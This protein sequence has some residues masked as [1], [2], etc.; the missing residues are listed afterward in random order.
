MST[1]KTDKREGSTEVV[2]DNCRVRTGFRVLTENPLVG[3]P[4]E[5]EFFIEPVESA[6]LFLSVAG[7]SNRQRP[8]QFEFTATLDGEEVP[9][10]LA[11]IPSVGGP[12]GVVPVTDETPWRQPLVLN[13]FLALDTCQ[14][15]LADGESA[16]LNVTC[17][18]ALTLG[19]DQTAVLTG[20]DWQNTSIDLALTICR[21]DAALA[22]LIDVLMDEVTSGTA[23]TRLHPFELLLSLRSVAREQLTELAEFSDSSIA[24]RAKQVRDR[25]TKV[26]E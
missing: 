21:D 17:R 9:D 3:G 25:L 24:N 15:R 6:S 12:V 2:V 13:Q 23:A 7:D 26:S 1:S 5:L 16:R 14:Q 8:G 11:D 22:K 4:I 20:K 10:P 19:A 18:R